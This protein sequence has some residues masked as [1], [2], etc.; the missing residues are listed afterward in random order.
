MML[1]MLNE[2]PP[3]D[4]HPDMKEAV[5]WYRK[6]SERDIPVAS[7]QLARLYEE[8]KG[9]DKDMKQSLRYYKLAAGQGNK[10]AVEKLETLAGTNV[11]R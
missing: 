6:A 11:T 8:G 7:L 2:F 4:H 9:V 10:E 5:K 3:A 1:G